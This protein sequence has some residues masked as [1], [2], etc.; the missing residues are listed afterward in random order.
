MF[1]SY[2]DI[3][4]HYNMPRGKARRLRKA[5]NVL[6][7]TRRLLMDLGP[8]EAV[9]GPDEA[10]LCI[11]K[12]CADDVIYRT[13]E[14]LKNRWKKVLVERETP[15]G[16]ACYVFQYEAAYYRWISIGCKSF[17]L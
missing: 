7:N 4:G 6:D 3:R 1:Q 8:Y 16:K 12:Q 15:S 5:L 9:R 17:F 11:H 13:I 10:F 14:L 2:V